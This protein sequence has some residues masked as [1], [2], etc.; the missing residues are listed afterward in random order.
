[1]RLVLA[2]PHRLVMESLAAALTRRGLDVVAV[3]TSPREVFAKVAEHRP[4]FCLLAAHFPACSGLGVLR[5]ISKRHPGVGVVMLSSGSDPGLAKAA[6]RCGAAAVISRDRH[7]SDIERVLA[8]V[9]QRKRAFGRGL[10]EIAARDFRLSGVGDGPEPD[11]L[12]SRE[13]EVLRHIAE[14]E[15]TRQIACSLGISEA[16]VRTHVQNVLSKLGVHSRLEATIVA[17][18]AGLPGCDLPGVRT[19]RA[20]GGR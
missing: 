20:A 8:R 18:Q 2:G 7:I 13:R 16:T 10:L 12:T 1:M 9:G 6:S 15:R 17:A 19:R 5:V 14:G 11:R 4:D 3:A